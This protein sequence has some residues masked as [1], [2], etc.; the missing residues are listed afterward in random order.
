MPGNFSKP[1]APSA[2]DIA[3]AILHRHADSRELSREESGKVAHYGMLYAQQRDISEEEAME[4]IFEALERP[5][6][7]FHPDPPEV[8]ILSHVIGLVTDPIPSIGARALNGIA[9]I[10]GYGYLKFTRGLLGVALES[11]RA[12]DLADRLS[13]HPIET[14]TNFVGTGYLHIV[15][16]AGDA[17]AIRRVSLLWPVISN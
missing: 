14:R 6:S 3:V 16:L 12:E 11:N 17:E 2:F 9:R 1:N 13:I 10:E 8:P 15:E 5:R 7:S 4:E